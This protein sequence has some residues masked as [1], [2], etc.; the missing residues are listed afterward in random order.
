MILVSTAE[1]TTSEAAIFVRLWETEDKPLSLQMARQILRLKFSDKDRA[2]MHL[3]A[4]KNQEGRI[5]PEELAE[6]DNFVKVGDL[7]AILQ[8]R[9]RQRLQKQQTTGNGHE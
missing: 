6:L 4:V 5:A 3:L 8:S 9:A 1:N 2:R 7:L